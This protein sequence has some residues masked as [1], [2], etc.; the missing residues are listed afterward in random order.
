M[1]TR[2]EMWVCESSQKSDPATGVR[3]TSPV[4]YS[5]LYLNSRQGF[6]GLKYVYSVI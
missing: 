4:F 1:K 6:N 2:L 3:S 5:L